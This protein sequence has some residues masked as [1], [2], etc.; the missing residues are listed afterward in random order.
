M[1]LT[2]IHL[3]RPLKHIPHVSRK[4]RTRRIFP[5]TWISSG[6][7]SDNEYLFSSDVEEEKVFSKDILEKISYIDELFKEAE[8]LL[9]RMWSSFWMSELFKREVVILLYLYVNIAFL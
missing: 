4:T 3:G 2:N 5:S 7:F 1:A 6:F 8:E 9:Q